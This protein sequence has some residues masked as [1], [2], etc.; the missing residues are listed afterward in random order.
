MAS[1]RI[2]ATTTIGRALTKVKGI[3]CRFS[4]IVGHLPKRFRLVC[5]TLGK[6]FLMTFRRSRHFWPANAALLIAIIVRA[7]LLLAPPKLTYH[8]PECFVIPIRIESREGWQSRPVFQ[9]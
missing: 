8:F 4:H 3:K 9:G 5:R 2:K 6:K 7:Y 1:Q